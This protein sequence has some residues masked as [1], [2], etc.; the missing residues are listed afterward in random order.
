[1][2]I[3]VVGG[4][5]AGT[6]FAAKMRR[7]NKDANIIMIEKG[8]V[9]SL[10]ACGLPFYV[11]DFFDNS[12]NMIART[13]QEFINSGIDTRVHHQ[14]VMLDEK[15][16]VLTIKNLDNDQE[17][18][19][20]YDVLVLACGAS[21][22][23]VPFMV[24]DSVT[25][26]SLR[27]LEDGE[28]LRKT[29]LSKQKMHVVIIGAGFIGIEIV[30]GALKLGHN[31]SIIDI[32]DKPMAHTVD[33]EIQEIILNELENNRVGGYYG[34]VVK[35]ISSDSTVI[36][37]DGRTIVADVIIWTAGIKANTDW[38]QSSGLSMERGIIQTNRNGLT[39][40][41]DVYAIGDCATVHH[42]LLNKPF[43]SPLATVANKM[44]R[45]LADYL[46]DTSTNFSGMMGSAS[47]KVC[48]L[49]VVRVG[50]SE[51]E[52]KQEGIKYLISFIEDMDHTNYYPNA[53]KIWIKLI[54]NKEG[55]ILGAQLAGKHGAALRGS[56]M[57]FAIAKKM[58]VKELGM[59]DIP[60]SPPFS[61]TWDVLNV[62]G[63][64][65]KL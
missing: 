36:L 19:Q 30:E 7:N 17:Y 4:T 11:G 62:A 26:Y 35:E 45:F 51:K 23:P 46:M 13:P 29:L 40:L 41:K 33:T 61:R 37:E 39:N 9:T 47:L 60:Y 44:G 12:A 22:L 63:N 21:S 25:I 55:V 14:A 57:S 6:T 42:L 10:G 58:T 3:I 59:L 18:Q 5:A 38:L 15:N 48:D 65:S 53:Q 31:V 56:A 20:F 50:L 2:D 27:K 49:E 43:Y 52:A 28:R 1:M 24:A 16:K 64:V 34:S 54:Y 8:S 32:A